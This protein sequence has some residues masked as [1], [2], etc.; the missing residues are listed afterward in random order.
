M[1]QN[2]IFNSQPAVLATLSSV[3]GGNLFNST[4]STL[5]LGGVGYAPTQ[6]YAIIKHIRVDNILTT[7]AAFATLYKGAT[8]AQLSTQAWAISSVSIPAQS[9][10][11]WYGQARFDSGDFLTGVCN[12]STA[13]VITIEGE[14]GLS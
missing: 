6:P 13:C 10:I 12:L 5:A 14:V 3:S 7:T 9:Y 4:I 1:A 2:K 8:G 11:D